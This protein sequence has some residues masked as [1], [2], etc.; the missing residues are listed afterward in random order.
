MQSGI[1]VPAITPIKAD[2]NVDVSGIESLVDHLIGAGVKGLF[3]FGTSGEGPSLTRQ[4]RRVA[5]IAF[6]S[7]TAQRVP[8][9]AGIAGNSVAQCLE[10]LDDVS[11]AGV[12]KIVIMPPFF[13]AGM[14]EEIVEQHLRTLATSTSLPVVLYNI[15]QH[16]QNPITPHMLGRLAQI[17]NVVAL[18]DSS[19]NSEVFADLLLVGQRSGLEVFQGAESM[20]YSGLR[21][22]A[23]GA[24]P[25]IGNVAPRLVCS[26]F[27]AAR[28][29]DW[30][31]AERLQNAVDQACEILQE[32]YW[33][34]ALKYAV[35]RVISSSPALVSSMRSA[36]A[37]EATAIDQILTA[38][39]IDVTGETLNFET[40]G[41]S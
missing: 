10:S 22:G 24:V 8:V 2:G 14:G 35:S 18:K 6:V 13:L 12:D 20:I 9:L 37:D 15:P 7:S 11:D 30:D 32:A 26:L 34:V 3:I 41:T 19:A 38:G 5:A 17:P 4:Q 39:R 31:E 29:G 1:V 21:A 33:L 23:D 25:G 36:N 40:G 28:L 16:T 27:E